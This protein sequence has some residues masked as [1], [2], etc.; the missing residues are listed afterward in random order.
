MAFD[1]FFIDPYG[2]VM[3]CNGTKEKEVMGNINDTDWDTL[4]SS[5]QAEQVRAKV[6]CCDRQCWMICQILFWL[7]IWLCELCKSSLHTVMY[8]RWRVLIAL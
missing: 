7:A 6:R 8:I 3:P 4:W 1:T 2:D 5:P